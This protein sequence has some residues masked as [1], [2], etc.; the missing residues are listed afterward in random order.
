MVQLIQAFLSQVP[1]FLLLAFYQLC[2][3]PPNCQM[4]RKQAPMQMTDCMI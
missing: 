2:L 4:A 1:A 3:H